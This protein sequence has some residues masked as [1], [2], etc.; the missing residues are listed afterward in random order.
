MADDK[1]GRDKQADDLDKR[2]RQRDLAEALERGDE[3]EPEVEAEDLKDIEK[4]FEAVEFPATGSE[5]V[6]AVGTQTVEAPD[7]TYAVEN[8]IPE[9]EAVVF[10]KPAAVRVRIQ[11]PTIAAAMKRVL[12]AADAVR[13]VEVERSQREAYEKTFRA[14]RAIDA[15]D[16]DEGIEVVTDWIVERI[17]T[18][19]KLPN[20]R[21]V[22]KRAAEFCRAN[23]YPIR[24]DEWLGA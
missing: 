20:S 5:V 21:R 19:E 22:R 15:D 7:G 3:T 14:L 8:L 23:G 13:N 10:E 1:S 18:K 2:Q 17:R 24:D 16:D 9:T 11:R 6:H 4:A 12:E